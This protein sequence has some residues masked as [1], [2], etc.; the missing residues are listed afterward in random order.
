M[1]GNIVIVVVLLLIA[2]GLFGLA[3][4]EYSIDSSANL[5]SSLSATGGIAILLV[6]AHNVWGGPMSWQTRWEV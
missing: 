2:A 6:I 4:Y 3:Y 5:L 1:A